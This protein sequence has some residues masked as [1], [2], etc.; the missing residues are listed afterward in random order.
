MATITLNIPDQQME[1]V[2]AALCAINGYS[3]T[4]GLTAAEFAKACLVRDLV[5]TVRN[6]ERRQAEDAA[7]EQVNVGPLIIS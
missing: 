3:D 6:W 2:V 4:S 7:L 1:R 5:G